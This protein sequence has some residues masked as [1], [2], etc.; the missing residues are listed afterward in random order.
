M[1]ENTKK[2]TER[3]HRV[4]IFRAL[5]I[6]VA[7][8]IALTVFNLPAVATSLETPGFAAYS[9]DLNPELLAKDSVACDAD[10]VAL[11]VEKQAEYPGGINE[12]MKFL[13][14]TMKYPE[15]AQQND[16]QGRVIVQFI[17]EK[18]GAISNANIIN[19][20]DPDLDNEA[21]RVVNAM[22]KWTPGKIGD[23]PVR[24]IFT[25]P[26]NFKLKSEPKK[27]KKDKK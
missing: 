4:R 25:M 19:S 22:P 15:K 1:K 12:L 7:P 6:A 23:T 8:M 24:S 16:I 5:A 3:N 14:R 2:L 17:I 26:L 27:D 11:K 9:N 10:T 13:S 18:D 20:V 21:L